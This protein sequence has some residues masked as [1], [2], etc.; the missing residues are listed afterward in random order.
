[1]HK[2][3]AVINHCWYRETQQFWILAAWVKFILI[4]LEEGQTYQFSVKVYLDESSSNLLRLKELTNPIV[5]HLAWVF[6]WSQGQVWVDLS[7]QFDL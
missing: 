2:Q 3:L 6:E 5:L 7:A 1:M 4:D